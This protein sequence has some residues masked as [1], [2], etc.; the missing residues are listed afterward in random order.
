MRE[1]E[2]EAYFKWMVAKLGGKSYKFKSVNSRGVADRIAMLSNG[3]TWF[4]E[5]KA[6]GK[7]LAPL[8]EDFRDDCLALKQRWVYLTTKQEIEQ[9]AGCIAK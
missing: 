1:S 5:L 8:Q 4:V 3:D 6:P 2:I 7:K 9:W